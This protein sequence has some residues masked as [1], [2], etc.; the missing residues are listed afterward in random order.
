MDDE[1]S[2]TN[3]E[4]LEKMVQIPI[5]RRQG[6]EFAGFATSE[7]DKSVHIADQ[8]GTWII[9]RADLISLTDWTEGSPASMLGT[10]RPVRA[11][12]R[13]SATIYEIRPWQIRRQKRDA[14]A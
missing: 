5:R 14:H 9:N 11:I 8:Q 10:G 12:V 13:E 7:D 1:R 3:I 4:N 6:V 2:V